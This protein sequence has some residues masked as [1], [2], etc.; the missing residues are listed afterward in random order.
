MPLLLLPPLLCWAV[1][2][3]VVAES[4]E[5]GR[6]QRSIVAPRHRR[7]AT[8]SGTGAQWTPRPENNDW[9]TGGQWWGRPVGSRCC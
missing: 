5:M 2:S 1:D 4:A 7:R 6:W 9:S 8:G 3:W